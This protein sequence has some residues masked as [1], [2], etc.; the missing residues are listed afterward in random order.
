MFEKTKLSMR[1]KM[2]YF[3]SV[4]L[5]LSLAVRANMVKG[6]SSFETG[7]GPWGATSG[8]IVDDTAFDGS[9]SMK[10]VK[11]AMTQD[12]YVLPYGK[13]HV[14]SV[15]LKSDKAGGKAMIEA[16]PT[17]WA[18]P[19]IHKDVE[20]TTEWKRYTLN[21]RE[22]TPGEHNKFWLRV[23]PRNDAVVWVDAVQLEQG[24]A[25]T[26]WK[27]AD[28]TSILVAMKCKVDGAIYFPGEEVAY[29]TRIYNST[30]GTLGKHL[31]VTVVDYYGKEV[32]SSSNKVELAPKKTLDST[33]KL[34]VLGKKG[35]YMLSYLLSDDKGVRQEGTTTFCVVDEP[36]KIAKWKPS[37][38]GMSGGPLDRMPSL[39]RVGVKSQAV[40]YRWAYFGKDGKLQD[41]HNKSIDTFVDQ[42]HTY[43]IEPIMYLRRTPPWAAMAQH[44][45]DIHPP[46]EEF[47]SNYGEFAFQVAQHY[48]GRVRHYQMWGGEADLLADTVRNTFGTDYD[49]NWFTDRVAALHIA[50][51]DGIKKADPDAFVSSTGVSGVDCTFARF[52]FL[53]T[54]LPKLQGKLDEV[55]IHPYC[56]PSNFS[57]NKYVQTPEDNKLDV[58]YREIS[59]IAGGKPV[60]N[61]EFGFSIDINE[62]LDSAASRRMADY[63]ARSFLL[64]ASCPMVQRVMWYTVAGNYDAFSIWSWPNPRPAVAAYAAAAH[65]LEN[66]DKPQGFDMGSL[67]RGLV[68]NRDGK[69][70]GALWSPKDRDVELSLSEGLGVNA[71][72]IMGN[73]LADRYRITL[74]G[75]PVYFTSDESSDK[76]L[77]YLRSGKLLIQPFEASVS[78]VN[79]KQLML[80][81]T[82]QLDAELSGT[83]TLKVPLAGDAN[84]EIVGKFHKLKPG[85]TKQIPML[86]GNALDIAA[87]NGGA[88]VTGTLVCDRGTAK[89]EQSLELMRC[90]RA[91]GNAFVIDGDVKDWDGIP[92][93]ELNS[94]LYLFPP[95]AASASTWKNAADLSVSARVAWDESYFYFSAV[96]LDDIHVNS[97]SNPLE[98][99]AGDCIQMGFDTLNDARTAGYLADDREIN[100]GFS[101]AE[102]KPL[103][104]QSWP[105]PSKVPEGCKVAISVLPGKKVYELAIPFELLNPLK[106]VA[107]NVF[108]YNFVAPD[109][110][111]KGNDYWMGL[112]YGICG[113]KNP[114][115]FK[116]FILTQP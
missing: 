108:G 49:L 36:R 15:Y 41:R 82:N 106:P 111:L 57:G 92:S 109:T 21:L 102:N 112:T 10:T 81:V 60:Q 32:F 104:S 28:E 83:A 14:L 93:I 46:K 42:C 35:F 24:E 48:K 107:G 63:L 90:P 100:M 84:A 17:N 34:P 52:T 71:Y 99:W 6:D 12:I 115:C 4:L 86:L 80:H 76:L 94:L 69:S 23:I 68:L 116:K 7:Y 29:M 96:V 55:T 64:S 47:I 72:D 85:A 110:D 114:S 16:Y 38:F 20:L 9:H 22:L 66:T 26:P 44:P 59:R 87:L 67:V 8:E 33:V 27:S 77:A 113:G 5:L 1:Q 103:L 61:G 51:Y 43:G 40:A 56:Y 25:A 58:A 45:H 39:A 3:V 13:K 98:I 89:F 75:S 19:F 91:P 53:R 31:S 18:S 65:F 97:K 79:D 95:D 30:E 88:K 37:L 73:E 11:N 105:L 50:G 54:L 70:V 78:V 2:K 62:K 74:S 101:T